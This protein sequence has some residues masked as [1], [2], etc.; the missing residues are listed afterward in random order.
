MYAE[1]LT[2]KGRELFPRLSRFED[3]YLAG[4]T[5]LALQIG[6]R[7]SVDFDLFTAK[8]LPDR[9]LQ[10]VKQ[11]FE[12]S[13]VVTTYNVPNQ[14]N[15]FID[16]VKSTFF[17]YEYPIVEPFILYENVP[18]ASIGEIAAMKAFSIGKRLSY[19]DYVDWYFLLLEKYVTLP[20]VIA[21]AQQKFKNDFNDRLFLGQLVSFNDIEEVP[22]DFLREEVDRS[23]I[24]SFL[25]EHVKNAL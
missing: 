9:I 1:A 17:Q 6:H 4:G 13:V 16:N 10:K 5:A 12:D 21:L 24:T 20:D 8:E 23:T 18:L 3:F 22:I 2:D 14:L 25:A 7:R 15:V 11:I 19:K